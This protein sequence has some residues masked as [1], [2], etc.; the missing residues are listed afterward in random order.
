M[1]AFIIELVVLLFVVAFLI[2]A[3]LSGNATLAKLAWIDGE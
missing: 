3:L 1:E 2:F